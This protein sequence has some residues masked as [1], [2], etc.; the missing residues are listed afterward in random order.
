ML[1]VKEKSGS[2]FRDLKFINDKMTYIQQQTP[3]T[4]T[5]IKEIGYL[6]NQKSFNSNTTFGKC[7]CQSVP[8]LREMQFEKKQ[9][10]PNDQNRNQTKQNILII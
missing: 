5:L 7:F 9:M 1:Y 10:K 4:H 8:Y 2:Y 6:I 3:H